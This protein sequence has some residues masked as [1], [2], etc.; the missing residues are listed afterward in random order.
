MTG[1]EIAL[2][3]GTTTTVG[4]IVFGALKIVQKVPS[5]RNGKT[6]SPMTLAMDHR[7]CYAAVER[8][9]VSKDRY[10]E[11]LERY[12]TRQGSSC[13]DSRSG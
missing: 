3:S 2:V 5:S 6:S 4:T 1:G 9:V 11:A 13:Y 8:L 7:P 10:T 12:I